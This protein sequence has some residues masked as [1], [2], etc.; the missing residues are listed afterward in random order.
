M[1][2]FKKKHAKKKKKPEWKKERKGKETRSNYTQR[3]PPGGRVARAG[4]VFY[5][6][7]TVRVTLL[8]ALCPGGRVWGFLVLSVASPTAE[9][10]LP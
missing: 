3:W 8:D 2:I 10:P 9:T 6:P 7:H 5:A 4:P 1:S